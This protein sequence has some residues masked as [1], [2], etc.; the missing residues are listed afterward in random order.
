LFPNTLAEALTKCV[1]VSSIQYIWYTL[2]NPTILKHIDATLTFLS[3]LP[4]NV[5]DGNDVCGAMCITR[6]TFN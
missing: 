5:L 6:P 4:A 2:K 3:N 1:S